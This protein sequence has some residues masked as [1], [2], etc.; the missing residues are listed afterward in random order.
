[1]MGERTPQQIIGDDATLQ[2]VFEGYMVIKAADVSRL[3]AEVKRL[4]YSRDWVLVPRARVSHELATLRDCTARTRDDYLRIIQEGQ[5][6]PFGEYDNTRI[7]FDMKKEGLI[8]P[9]PSKVSVL[10]PMH[11]S[12]W[13]RTRQAS[14]GSGT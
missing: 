10:T 12:L 3:R 9:N 5:T 11:T 8:E 7:L 6:L 14:G 1:M 2:L 13:F 4:Q